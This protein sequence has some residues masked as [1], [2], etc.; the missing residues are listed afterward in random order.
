[1]I[2]N[3]IYAVWCKEQDGS[4]L[5][6]R[7]STLVTKTAKQQQKNNESC[8][9][10]GERRGKKKSGPGSINCKPPSRVEHADSA[11]SQSLIG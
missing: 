4:K 5:L 11:R 3:D 1:M 10:E 6:L 8:G 7:V 2:A 9:G